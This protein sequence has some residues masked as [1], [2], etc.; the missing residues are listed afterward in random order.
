MPRASASGR[1]HQRP[2]EMAQL[3]PGVEGFEVKDDTH[4]KAKVKIPLGLGG[5]K[6]SIDFEKLEERPLEFASMN[7]K[8]KGVGALMDMTTSFTLSGEGEHTSMAWEA[9]VK[10]AGA[11]RLDGP[12]R[13]AADHQPA[14][15]PG[16][17]RRS[18]ARSKAG[19]VSEVA[20]WRPVPDRRDAADDGAARGDAR[21]GARHGRG[22][23]GHD[24]ARRGLPVVAQA[25]HG[26][27]LVDG[28]SPAD[29][30]RD[31]PLAVGWGIIS[32]YTR[33]PVQAAMD[34]RVVQEAAGPGR[35]IVG[36]RHLEDLPQQHQAGRVA[37]GDE[38]ARAHARL[39]RDHARHPRRRAVRVRRQ[40]LLGRHPGALG[41][42]RTRRAGTSR[43][44]SPARRR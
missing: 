13:P 11:G 32:P 19:R 27:A 28:R 24:L 35:F 2:R 17:R 29:R 22:G 30:A 33:H 14:G 23:H 1:V 43:C 6:M 10:I 39:G 20:R 5:L 4:W 37:A 34:A 25:R 41:P 15:R 12:A 3:M 18:S 42:R 26:G 7:A 36:L 16:A 38:A 40:G 31:E 21:V 8:G 9:D 44:T